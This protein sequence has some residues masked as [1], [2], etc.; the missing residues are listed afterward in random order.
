V[1]RTSCPTL[2][3][4]NES[5]SQ[6]VSPGSLDEPV[7]HH[8]EMGEDVASIIKCGDFFVILG[9]SLEGYYLVKCLSTNADTFSGTYFELSSEKVPNKVI[10]SDT[11]KGDT[12]YKR[13]VVSQ[14]SVTRVSFDKRTSLLAVDKN[15]LDDILLTISEMGDI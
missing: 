4:R 8:P 15:E 14:I 9:D 13:T 7:E 1:A 12:F 3:S 6:L 10:F 5:G 2:R 11:H